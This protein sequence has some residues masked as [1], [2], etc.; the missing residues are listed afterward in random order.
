[1]KASIN[2][3]RI[4]CIG[5]LVLGISCK[6]DR[7]VAKYTGDYT[8]TGKVIDEISGAGIAWANVGVIER[9]RFHTFKFYLRLFCRNQCD[10][11]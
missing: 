4:I 8:I 1:M 5:I 9:G 11:Q 6:K 3:I 2:S 10:F 7:E